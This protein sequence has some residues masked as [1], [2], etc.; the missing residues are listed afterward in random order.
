M[1]VLSDL[2]LPTLHGM[3]H[4]LVFWFPN[5]CCLDQSLYKTKAK[6]SCDYSFLV[7]HCRVTNRTDSLYPR[8]FFIYGYDK[9][10]D[11][12]KNVLLFSLRTELEKFA[13]LNATISGIEPSVKNLMVIEIRCCCS[14][15]FSYIKKLQRI[16]CVR[17]RPSLFF[18]NILYLR[19]FAVSYLISL[20]VT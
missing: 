8:K 15:I 12:N 19:E 4:T 6:M 9:Y 2:L 16:K 18:R 10:N 7:I 5:F 11:K 20:N 3:T 13:W 1:S 14:L 17:C